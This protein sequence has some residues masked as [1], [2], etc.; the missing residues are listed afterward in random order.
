MRT[1][2]RE[3]QTGEPAVLHIEARSGAT[4]VEPHDAAAVRI[5]AT[6]RVWSDLPSDLDEAVR[7]V[8]DGM[9]HDGRRVIVRAP[10]LPM[11]EGWSLWSGRRG[12][13]VDYRV[14]APRRTAVRALS[15]SGRVRVSGV[16]GRVHVESLTG[17]CDVDAVK[18]SVTVSVRS[19]GASVQEIDGD[20]TIEV[21]SGRIEARDIGGALVAQSRSGAVEARAV[22]GGVTATTHTG[23]IVV[24]DVRSAA[25]L[26]THTGAIRYLGTVLADLEA[27]AH[28]GMIQLAVDTQRPFFLDAESRLGVVTSDLP[29]RR[30]GAAADGAGPRVRLRTQTGAIRITRR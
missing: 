28:T 3:F 9:Q 10:S 26:R 15:R 30:A 14:L 20:V 13:R 18:G 17:R 8:E 16:E 23:T 11:A 25:R 21:R 24:E 7:L 22:A 6:V 29:P 12:G 19:G 5:E 4:V 2:T 27:E 1:V